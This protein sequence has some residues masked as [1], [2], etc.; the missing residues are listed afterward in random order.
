MIAF[1]ISRAAWQWE[2]YAFSSFT[3]QGSRLAC[4]QFLRKNPHVRVMNAFHF[5]SRAYP[6]MILPP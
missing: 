3:G 2:Q 1:L 5:V 4:F 6:P